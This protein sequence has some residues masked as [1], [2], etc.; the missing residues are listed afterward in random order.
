MADHEDPGVVVREGQEAGAGAE[1]F[2]RV[3][4]N[5]SSYT[6]QEAAGNHWPPYF[7]VLD[8]GLLHFFKSLTLPF[9]KEDYFLMRTLTQKDKGSSSCLKVIFRTLRREVNTEIPSRS[10]LPSPTPRVPPFSFGSGSGLVY[11]D[12]G[13][14]KRDPDISQTVGHHP[15]G[16]RGKGILVA[17]SLSRAGGAV[18]GRFCN[19]D[20]GAVS[21]IDHPEVSGGIE[22]EAHWLCE[23]AD[24]WTAG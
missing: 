6:A 19:F 22:G 8:L 9:L 2:F 14:G 1:T 17:G 12:F 5:Q 16:N 13:A 23:V 10:S 3:C 4:F 21:G 7:P 18:N 15:Y 11:D 24:L 20:G